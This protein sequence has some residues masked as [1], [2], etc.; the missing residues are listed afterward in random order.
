[1]RDEINTIKLYLELEAFRFE[2]NEFEF[3][4]YTRNIEDA[5]FL[6]L[7]AFLIQPHIE[8]AIKHG[9]LH[10]RDFKKL[11]LNIELLDNNILQVEIIDNGIGRTASALI[12]KKRRAKH[13]S[14]ATNAILERIS[15]INSQYKL[16]I[17]LKTEDLYQQNNPS[18][19]KVTIKIPVSYER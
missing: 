18:G 10:K 16:N 11:I 3:N 2:P 7:P 9:L 19:T 13:V 1:L 4:I 8:N 14:F 5:S 12:N 6:K 17:S 15:L